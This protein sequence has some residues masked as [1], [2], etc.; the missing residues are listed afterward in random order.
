MQRSGTTG[1]LGVHA[2]DVLG[3]RVHGLSV[4]GMLSV[5]RG[6]L[7]VPRVGA[8]G[9]LRMGVP[10]VTGRWVAT[11]LAVSA[12]DLCLCVRKWRTAAAL[13]L[14]HPLL[15]MNLERKKNE[16]KLTM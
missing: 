3:V 14:P 1:V 11:S 10:R 4:L 9:V 16:K 6:K 2:L 7:G 5:S 15:E 13:W 12:G 8:L